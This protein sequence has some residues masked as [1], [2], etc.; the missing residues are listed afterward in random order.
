MLKSVLSKV[1]GACKAV[2]WD[3]EVQ[4]SAKGVAVLVAIRFAIALGASPVVVE[5]VRTVLGG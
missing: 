3:T 1:V 5:F 4:R 2:I